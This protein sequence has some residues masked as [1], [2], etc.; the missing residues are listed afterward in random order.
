MEQRG[1]S[2][3]SVN[4][5]PPLPPAE[6]LRS[7]ESPGSISGVSQ[8]PW[9]RLRDWVGPRMSWGRGKGGASLSS[10]PFHK[11][12]LRA[13]A[14]SAGCSSSSPLPHRVLL[15]AFPKPPQGAPSFS[16]AGNHQ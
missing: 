7:P 14:P 11:Y 1:R 9:D 16:L 8:L 13:G 5:T 3:Y 4:Q 10:P 6:S 12:G 2:E 15:G